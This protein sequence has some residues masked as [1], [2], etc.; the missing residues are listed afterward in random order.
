[1]HSRKSKIALGVATLVACSAC[2]FFTLYWLWPPKP[3]CLVL[4]GAG[5][6]NNLGVPHNVYGWEGLNALAEFSQSGSFAPSKWSSAPL[7]LK[8]SPA[9]LATTTEWPRL[10]DNF[11]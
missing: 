2:L 7:R 8:E 10:L 3:A 5:Y 11:A 1:N 9:R 6:E 4:I